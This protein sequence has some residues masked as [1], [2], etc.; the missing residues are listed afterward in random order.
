VE[1][2]TLAT[3]EIDDLTTDHDPLLS[4][5][6]IPLDKALS[7]GRKTVAIFA[8]PAYCTSAACG[9]MLDQTKTMA[10]AHPDVDF[11]HIEVYGGFNEPGFAP[12]VDHLVPAVVAFGLPTEPWVFVMD[13]DGVVTGRFDGV[14]GDNEVEALLGPMGE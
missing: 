10:H 5:Y 8:T 6:E 4:L 2:P 12:D 14:L 7:N 3:A 13:E 9:P 11:L 1:T